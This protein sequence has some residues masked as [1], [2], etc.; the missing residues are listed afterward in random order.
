LPVVPCL[1]L[2][3]FLD[4]PCASKPHIMHAP[5]RTIWQPHATSV[6]TCPCPRHSAHSTAD[7][8]A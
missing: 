8:C 2:P 1:L 7:F 3:L 5:S 4:P 6:I